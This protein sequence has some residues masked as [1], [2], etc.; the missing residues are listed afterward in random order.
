MKKKP[1]VKQVPL[2]AK[3]KGDL[4]ISYLLI[5]LGYILLPVVTPNFYTLDTAGPKFLSLSILNLIGFIVLVFDKNRS[6]RNEVRYGFF[7]NAVGIAFSVLLLFNL[8][9]FFNAINIT[10]SIVNFSKVST[11]FASTYILYM[12]FRSNRKYL[13][14]LAVTVSLILLAD[15][16]TVFYNI[17]KYISREISSIYEIK[18]V[19]SNK[20]ILSSALFVK[21]PAAIYLIFFTKGWLRILGYAT[22]VCATIATF[23]MSTRTFYIGLAVLLMAILG[24]V[25][26]RMIAERNR[27]YL[28]MLGSWIGIFIIAIAAYTLAQKYLFPR[29]ADTT[30]NTSISQRLSSIGVND[31]SSN[32]RLRSWNRSIKLIKEDPL[33]GVGTGNWKIRVLKYENPTIGDYIYMYKNHND[34]L[35]ITAETG[36][37]GGIAFL[38][39][40]IF[41]VLYFARSSLKPDA[42]ASNLKLLFLPA[43][44]ILAYSVDAFFN[45][46]ADRPEMQALFAIYVG[47]AIAAIN[48]GGKK[49]GNKEA[50]TP[51]TKSINKFFNFPVISFILFGFLVSFSWV[52]FLNAKSL[53]FQR[54]VKEDLARN[55]LTKSAN[56]IIA[57]FP[58]I[59]NIT[60]DGEPIAVSKAR[61]LLNEKRYKEALS[62]LLP[63]HASPWDSRREYFLTMAYENLN[64]KDSAYYFIRQAYKLKP[65]NVK[66]ARVVS[67]MLWEAGKR[68]EA[69]QVMD[70][71]LRLVKNDPEPWKQAITYELEDHDAVKAKALLD[72]AAKYNPAD[73]AIQSQRNRVDYIQ[74][75]APL[76]GVYSKAIQAFSQ[77]RYKEALPLLNE[78]ISKQPDLAEAYKMRAYC[79]YYANKYEQSIRDIDRYHS[80]AEVNYYLVSLKGINLS[81]TGRL[82][83]ACQEFK[84]AAD[85]ENPD[86]I[87]NYQKY[88]LKQ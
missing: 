75:R 14:I 37:I 17:L 66:A 48:Q 35:E 44:G 21:I 79:N 82:T 57:G 8:L 43:F 23:M 1:P 68:K 49:E 25:L 87:A 12:I 84:N 26:L 80:M 50:G 20:N 67:S 81:A 9:S 58:V 60:A 33:L 77:S 73:T 31:T 41:I 55:E 65:K 16:I 54:Y 85:H 63:D 10:E 51:L 59:P 32:M 38:F 70:S 69:K 30:W 47:L 39:I 45:F 13:N 24:Y 7:T 62:M 52:L 29:N 3:A 83:E 42:E 2:K 15:S 61:Y 71:L 36:I 22:S 88:C 27:R 6:L 4:N 19:Y 72:S 86:G 46:P 74:K 78:F 53:R 76:E 40:F 11:V 28:L 34:F 56:E 18:S 5:L 64:Q